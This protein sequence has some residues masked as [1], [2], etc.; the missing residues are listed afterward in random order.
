M[1]VIARRKRELEQYHPAH[2]LDSD[3][4]DAYWDKVLRM[5]AEQPL[6]IRREQMHSIFPSVATDKLTYL[7]HDGTPINAWFLVPATLGGEN[8]RTIKPPCIVTFPGY[9]CDRGLPERY[10][11][12][13][14]LG[15]AVL[16]VDAR[17]Q[18]GE[19]GNLLQE[20][21]GSAQGWVSMG[22]LDKEH[23]YYMALALD[24]VRAVEAAV[25]QPEI[26][27]AR[28]AAVGS[29]Q[30]GGMALL[31]GA[32]SDKIAVVVANIPNMCHLDYG[33]FHST[34]SLSEIAR[35]LKRHPDQ[36][37]AALETL[38][39]FDILNLAHRISASVLMSVSWKDTVCMPE[40]VYAA[41]NR[42]TCPKQIYDYPF[43]GHEIGEEHERKVIRFLQACFSI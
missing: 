10:S 11:A 36:L 21:S 34:G 27:T 17:G 42:L 25:L 38:A 9:G 37:D 14:L 6:A 15:Y 5:A 30:G 29:S 3:Q 4:I 19:T 39:H 24:V 1:N 12:W 7:G 40:A 8:E 13:L 32:L 35:Y 43:S 2:T 23:S 28:I 31:A 41:Y 26:D 33:V 20:E 22:L 16:A 18:F